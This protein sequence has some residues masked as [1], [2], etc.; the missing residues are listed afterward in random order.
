[1]HRVFWEASF[2]GEESVPLNRFVEAI[3]FVD[4]ANSEQA[5]AQLK[6][7]KVHEVT[8]QTTGILFN[9]CNLLN[10]G[11]KAKFMAL[12]CKEILGEKTVHCLEGLVTRIGHP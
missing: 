10:R 9:S 5:I 1:M 6:E 11:N 12:G 8:L 3:S 2:P 4:P 7:Q